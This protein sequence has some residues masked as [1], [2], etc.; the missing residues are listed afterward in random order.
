MFL[1]KRNKSSELNHL[2]LVSAITSL[3]TINH[4]QGLLTKRTDIFFFFLS[5]ERKERWLTFSLA[6]H[7]R[8]IRTRQS[9]EKN[10][11]FKRSKVFVCLVPVC[12]LLS[13]KWLQCSCADRS[14]KGSIAKSMWWHWQLHTWSKNLP[15]V[16]NQ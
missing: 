5:E 13:G 2:N 14:C 11:H 12:S 9:K 7:K 16:P 1:K 6:L 10:N 4:E 8:H 3:W 15:C